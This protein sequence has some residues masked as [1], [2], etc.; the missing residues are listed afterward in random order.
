MGAKGVH[1]EGIKALDLT[2]PAA[3]DAG[4]TGPATPSASSR[5]ASVAFILFTVLLD[6]LAI[7]L[8]IP[9][10]PKLVESFAGDT[11]RAAVMFGLMS[12][13]WALMQLVFSPI[14]GAL[15]DRFGR[16]PVLLLSNFGL[17]LDYI[18]MALAPTLGWLFAGRVISGI[19][20]A[21]FSTATAYI[22]DVT[23]PE[24]RA[25]AF[26]MIGGAFGLGFVLGPALGGILGDIDARLPFWVAAGLSLANACYGYFILPES[27]KAE[28]RSPF[29]FKSANPIGAINLLRSDPVLA[30]LG[31]VLFFYHLA[32]AALPAVFVLY[33]GYRFGWGTKEV[34]L[35]L[36]AVGVF[37]AI[38]QAG[39]IRWAIAAFGAPQTLLIGIAAGAFGFLIQG[40]TTNGLVYVVGI[41]IFVIWGFITPSAQQMMTARL[42]PDRQG[43]LQGANA[44]LM[45]IANLAGP[46]VFS[47]IFAWAVA[48]PARGA[49]LAGLPF[50]L[51][52]LL[53]TIAFIIARQ[54]TAGAR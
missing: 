49:A 1:Q 13:S 12:A 52:A 3:I 34:G 38:V 29:R 2:R 41:P 21:T 22:A 46:L 9:V 23:E 47:Q 11:S 35:V 30:R 44:S 19:M 54:P 32:H 31:L 6:V 39:L 20:A 28:A 43:Q 14:A 50:V 16:R 17:G 7:G 33:A 40:L 45:S 53:L 18:L 26:G 42:G 5:R 36:A 24:K 27:L 25:A 4:M 37:S 8:V 48:E 51:A 10:L 15:S